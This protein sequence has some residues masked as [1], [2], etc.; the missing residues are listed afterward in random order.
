MFI[1]P[2]SLVCSTP[3][4]IKITQELWEIT[5]AEVFAFL[6]SCN[7]E[8]RPQAMHNGIQI[9]RLPVINIMPSLKNIGQQTPERMLTFFFYAFCKSTIISLH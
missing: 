5:D 6:H 2:A 9:L 7:T 3:N 1:R 8:S 4:F